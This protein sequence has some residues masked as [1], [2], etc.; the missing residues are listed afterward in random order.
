MGTKLKKFSEDP[1]EDEKPIDVYR[2]F[3]KSQYDNVR[4]KAHTVVN[5]LR[6]KERDVFKKISKDRVK[7]KEENKVYE[8][9]E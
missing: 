1:A 9:I 6:E 5:K 7:I 3:I 2:N 8:N 4:T